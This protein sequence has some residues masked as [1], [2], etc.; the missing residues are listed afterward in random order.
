MTKHD[1]WLKRVLQERA[2][3]KLIDPLAALD[4]KI[5]LSSDKKLYRCDTCGLVTMMP[6]CWNLHGDTRLLTDEEVTRYVEVGPDVFSTSSGEE[7]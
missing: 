2:E 7:Q 1:A 5:A 6:C 3:G 4:V